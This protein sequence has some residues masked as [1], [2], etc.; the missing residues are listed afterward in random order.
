MSVQ[1]KLAVNLK[2]RKPAHVASSQSSLR[3]P[4]RVLLFDHTAQL[5]G[6]EIALLD[7]IRFFDRAHVTPI[8][9]LGSEGPLAD[10]LRGIADLHILEISPDVLHTRKDTL[11]SSGIVQLKAAFNIFSYV[12]RLVDFIYAHNIELIHTNSLKADILGGIAGRG[13][14]GLLVY[15]FGPYVERRRL[16]NELKEVASLQTAG[17]IKAD[18]SEK[19][20]NELVDRFFGK[21]NRLPRH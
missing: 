1:I 17:F 12:L 5:G 9:V 4:R 20:M 6:G 2:Q 16:R 18:L 8:V 11:G 14:H 10:R 19:V 7:L 21:S 15:H 3:S 13:I